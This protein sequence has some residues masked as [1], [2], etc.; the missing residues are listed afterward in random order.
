MHVL[1]HQ[2]L[3]V[4]GAAT[5]ALP[6]SNH[7]QLWGFQRGHHEWDH[8]IQVGMMCGAAEEVMELLRYMDHND[9]DLSL[10]CGECELFRRKIIAMWGMTAR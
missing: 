9:P 10:V 1:H 7:P 2:S 3:G 8:G 6:D 4:A 5:R